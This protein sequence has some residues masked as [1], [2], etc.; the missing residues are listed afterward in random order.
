MEND[1][2]YNNLMHRLKTVQPVMEADAA[3]ELAAKVMKGVAVTGQVRNSRTIVIKIA[4]LVTS[5]AAVLMG[6]VFLMQQNTDDSSKNI[7]YNTYYNSA[8]TKTGTP[9][10]NSVTE[11]LDYYHEKKQVGNS[12]ASIKEKLSNDEKAKKY[13][14]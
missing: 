8:I 7:I 3:N 14:K 6:I 4:R 13:T 5:G 10:I 2:L 11:F 12:F 1:E 9:K